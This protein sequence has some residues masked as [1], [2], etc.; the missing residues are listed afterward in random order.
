[1]HQTTPK[2]TERDQFLIWVPGMLT[3]YSHLFQDISDARNTAVINDK[4][5]RLS[6]RET[7]LGGSGTTREK[8]YSFFSG[9]EKR[10]INPECME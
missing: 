6:L 4:L 9:M 7:Q 2:E 5:N 8:D 10:L 1:M 3:G